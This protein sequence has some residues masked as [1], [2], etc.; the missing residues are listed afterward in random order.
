MLNVP[1]ATLGL[2]LVVFALVA[3]PI[4]GAVDAASHP[5][6]TWRVAGLDRRHWVRVQA[7]LAPFGVGFA[8]AIA[9]FAKTRP[10]LEASAAPV[11]DAVASPV[12]VPTA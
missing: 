10:R 8:V 3:F 11:F 4:W 7:M 2:V 5:E 1:T 6:T 9:Y 12:E